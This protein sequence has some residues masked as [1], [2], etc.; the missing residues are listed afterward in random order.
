MRQADLRLLPGVPLEVAAD[1]QV[2]QLLRAAEF[3][4]GLD[5]D[6]VLPLHQRVQALV[7][8]DRRCRP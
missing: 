3:H 1:H 4:V 6:A 2:E 7:Q 5:L 8:V